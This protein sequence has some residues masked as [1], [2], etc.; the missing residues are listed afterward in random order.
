MQVLELNTKD[1]V[2]TISVKYFFIFH[3]KHFIVKLDGICKMTHQFYL[4]IGIPN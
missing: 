3:L 4:P 2:N 1:Y